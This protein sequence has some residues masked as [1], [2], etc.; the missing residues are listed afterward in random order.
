MLTQT[1]AQTPAPSHALSGTLPEPIL[2]SRS[3]GW[4]GIVVELQRFCDTDAVVQMRDHVLGVHIAGSV[5]L[6]QGRNGRTG[7]KLVRPGD[8]TITPM[9]EPKRWQHT[10]ETM[11]I[12]LKLAPACVQSIAGERPTRRDS[13]SATIWASGTR[14][15]RKSDDGF[16]AGLEPEGAASRIYAESLTTHS[17]SIC[18][19]I[20][21][22]R[23]S[24]WKSPE[25]SC[26]T[27]SSSGRSSTS[28]TICAK[29]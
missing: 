21:A 1:H 28:T 7:V 9:G 6:L 12:L 27:T 17:P 15:S 25:R 8:T 16:L 10:G 11:V 2:S 3:R 13:R 20:T 18:C 22:R 5:N 24:R 29:T 4:N 19:G 23:A 26:R 14:N